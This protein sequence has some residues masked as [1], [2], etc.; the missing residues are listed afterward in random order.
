MRKTHTLKA[1]ALIAA[2][3]SAPAHALAPLPLDPV[4]YGPSGSLS[5]TTIIV[6]GSWANLIASLTGSLS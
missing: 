4:G 3:L 1:L 6:P 5:L 2:I